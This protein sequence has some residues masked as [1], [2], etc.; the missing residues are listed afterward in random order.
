MYPGRTAWI[1]PEHIDPTR[2][3]RVN[4]RHHAD[5]LLAQIV[6]RLHTHKEHE[7]DE[8]QRRQRQQQ[9]NDTAA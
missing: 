6:A 1:A 4:H 7:L 5:E 9:T 2:T 3:P 8:H